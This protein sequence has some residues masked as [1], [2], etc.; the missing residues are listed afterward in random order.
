MCVNQQV[1]NKTRRG[2]FPLPVIKTKKKTQVLP[3]KW[4]Q[5]CDQVRVTEWPQSFS[6]TTFSLDKWT[7]TNAAGWLAASGASKC[8]HAGI[9]EKIRVL[10][11]TV[12]QLL[13]WLEVLLS[14]P[15]NP[16]SF[17]MSVV[18]LCVC[19]YCTAEWQRWSVWQRVK[20]DKI[21]FQDILS[22]GLLLQSKDMS[23]TFTGNLRFPTGMKAGS[24]DLLFWM[25]DLRGCT[26]SSPQD[27]RDGPRQHP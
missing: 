11:S 14:Q 4:S 22:S 2:S 20:S 9:L 27:C 24:R 17:F 13:R 16:K 10:S 25:S 5:C 21:I 7:K 8:V 6:Y 26:L 1:N 23:I 15:Q 19:L 18:S 3:K 12:Q